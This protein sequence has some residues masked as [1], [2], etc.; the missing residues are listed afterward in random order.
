MKWKCKRCEAIFTEEDRLLW[1]SH[2]LDCPCGCKEKG[3]PSPSPWIP[4]IEIQFERVEIKSGARKLDEKWTIELDQDIVCMYAAPE[5]RWER[6][7]HWVKYLFV[8]DKVEKL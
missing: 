3:Y 5:T 4:V 2:K 6:F 1:K 7:C 8:K